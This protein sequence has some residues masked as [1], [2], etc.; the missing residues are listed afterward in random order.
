M[1]LVNVQYNEKHVLS[2]QCFRVVREPG[3]MLGCVKGISGLH[4]RD[5]P[6]TTLLR[7]LRN[8]EA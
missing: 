7:A 8:F 3:F 5:M 6:A 2:S 1:K 4:S